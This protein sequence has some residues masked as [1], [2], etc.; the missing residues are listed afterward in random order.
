MGSVESF[1]SSSPT[2]FFKR[3]AFAPQSLL[4]L[5]YDGTLAPFHTQRHRAYPYPG[6]KALLEGISQSGSSRVVLITGRPIVELQSL[7]A[8]LCN[9][10]IYG[11]YGLEHRL[12]NG[13]Y[14]QIAI[15]PEIAESLSGAQSK[16]AVSGLGHSIEIK[17]GGLAIHWRGLPA[18]VIDRIQ[19][20]THK[21]LADHA[22][23]PGLILLEFDGGLELRVA[24]PNK[25]DTVGAILEGS[26]TN[27][28]VA[29]LGDD[30]TDEGAFNMLKSRGLTVLIRPEY[31][32]TNAQFWMRPPDEL[33]A[34]LQQ[35]LDCLSA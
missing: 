15:A 10:E 6:V 16:L 7:I 25:E 32:E 26:G 27:I 33:I 30:L 18:T 21:V 22:N 19:T 3:L 4:L 24:H 8:P 14:S 9:L 23:L 20:F 11:S 12:A 17:P 1:I 5:D 13:S 31:R 28:P 2:A 29:Y 35:W 34:F